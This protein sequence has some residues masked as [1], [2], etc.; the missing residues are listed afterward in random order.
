MPDEAR[1]VVFPAGVP[2]NLQ[3]EAR[4]AVDP[5]ASAEKKSITNQAD[6]D[7]AHQ[8]EGDLL[9][10]DEALERQ[11]RESRLPEGGSNLL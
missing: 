7:T 11:A 6:S 10:D 8:A 5:A 2:V 1:E 9:S 3:Q 4:A